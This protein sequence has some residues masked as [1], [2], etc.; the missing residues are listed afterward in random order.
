MRAPS[1]H[2]H[3]DDIRELRRR[4]AERIEADI[5]LLDMLSDQGPHGYGRFA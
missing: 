2:L 1:W 5:A 4:I 3:A